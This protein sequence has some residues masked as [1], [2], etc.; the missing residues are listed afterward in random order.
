M[1]LP[2][3][4]VRLALLACITVPGL[5]S[6][7]AQQAPSSTQQ[8]IAA[9][10][11]LRDSGVLSEDEY[12]QKVAALQGPGTAPR[13]TASTAG[14]PPVVHTLMDQTWN[15]PAATVKVPR[16]WGFSGG[17]LH[18]AGGACTVTGTSAVM[19]IEAPDGNEGLV[20]MPALRA[21][22][23]SDPQLMRQYASSGCLV[24]K[25]M[26]AEDFLK[27]IVIP[28][29]RPGAR[30]LDSGPDPQLEASLAQIRQSMAGL[31]GAPPTISSARVRISYTRYGQPVEEFVSGIT[32]CS[33]SQIPGTPGF[34]VDCTADQLFLLHAPA[35]QLDALAAR[36]DL[37]D[38]KPSPAWQQRLAQDNQ[39]YQQASQEHMLRQQ[40][41]N[42]AAASAY[43]QNN[44]DQMAAT[45]AKGQA[46][47][48]MIHRIGNTSMNIDKQ[49][50]DGIDHAAQGTALSMSNSNIYTDPNTGKQVQL[51]DQ[52]GD[53]YVNAEGTMTQQTNSASGPIG[54]GWWTEMVPSY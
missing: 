43:L 53:T 10:Q 17:V 21:Q 13:A 38:L 18:A 28:K 25:G 2:V 23:V 5:T 45:A 42:T 46:N 36:K 35:G 32:S 26:T 16:G 22:Y 34:S 27:N 7:Q 11:G 51:S 33:R 44:K 6:C 37:I 50:Q 31:R 29:A 47:V 19:H 14:G 49:R 52:Y 24:A 9:L 8:K 48:D 15:M 3:A 41:R 39:N 12:Q 20:A 40:D 1:K 30:I 54:G 4:A